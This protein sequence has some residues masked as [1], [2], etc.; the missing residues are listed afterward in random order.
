MAATTEEK[1]DNIIAGYTHFRKVGKS[2]ALTVPKAVR[3]GLDWVE[4][5][6]LFVTAKDNRVVIQSLV[7][8]MSESMSEYDS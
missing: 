2:M 4:G 5:Q 3:E 6:A 8:H 1:H 7:E